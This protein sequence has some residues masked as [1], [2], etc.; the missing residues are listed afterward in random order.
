[1]YMLIKRRVNQLSVLFYTHT[2]NSAINTHSSVIRELTIN[3]M[4]TQY[5]HIEG[6]LNVEFVITMIHNFTLTDILTSVA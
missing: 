3:S 1:M 4:C 2:E 5:N 6:L